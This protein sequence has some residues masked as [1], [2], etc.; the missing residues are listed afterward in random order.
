MK[1]IVISKP[2]DETVLQLVE[3]ASPE[4]PPQHVRIKVGLAGVNRADILQRMGMYPAPPGV[5]ADIPGL[6][7]A[8]SVDKL[9]ANVSSLREGD[10]VFGVVAG[11]AYAEQI[12]VHEREAAKVPTAM[13]MADAAA[14]PE[15][16]ITAYDALVLRGNLRPGERV[17]VHAVGSGVGTA[18]L[19][20][21]RA[22]GCYVTG[23]S[24]TEDKLSRAKQLGLDAGLH[25]PDAKNLADALQT[26]C[27]AGY[28]VV[29]DLVGGSYLPATLSA[30]ALKGRIVVV[31]LT[32]GPTAEVNLSTLLR[33]RITVMG[34]V[35]R[36]RPLEEKIQAADLL[37]R[38]L[39]P[40]L[41]RGMI[42]PVIEAT[43]PLAQ[44]AEAHRLM[45]SNTTF[46]KVLLSLE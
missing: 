27:G 21:A 10:R 23:T 35:L 11:G 9:G 38:T 41:A 44:A 45:S 42:K 5:P 31:G 26:D 22:L 17:L 46:G 2:G 39:S 3:R 40:W 13:S 25:I 28:D 34:T 32:G 37:R 36:S 24:R 43:F 29:L 14:I 19:Q 8:G 7:Y 12:V 6:E 18:G 33:K 1:A 30:M 16:F 4:P 15:A 20:V